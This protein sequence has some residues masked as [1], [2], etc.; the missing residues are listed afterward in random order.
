VGRARARRRLYAASDVSEG[1]NVEEMAKVY[2]SHGFG[3][4]ADFVAAARSAKRVRELDD[5]SVRPRRV[6]VSRNLR[7]AE[8]DSR[9][10]PRRTHGGPVFRR[11]R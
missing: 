10:A 7:V 11:L 6:S 4:S 5:E 9:R 3:R 8:A 1:L 2:E